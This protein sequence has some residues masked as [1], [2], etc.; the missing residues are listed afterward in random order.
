MG[1]AP[2]VADRLT[3]VRL[4]IVIAVVTIAPSAYAVRP[5]I[6]DDARVVGKH[7]AQLETWV[8]YE[9]TSLQHWIVPAI[10]P[11]APLEVT[12]GGVHGIV[13]EPNQRY[14]IAAP[15]LQAKLLLHEAKPNQLPGVALIAGTF[16]PFGFGGFESPPSGFI[17]TAVTQVIGDDA[18]L[19]H[20]NLGFAGAQVEERSSNTPLEREKHARYRFTWG[21]AT[22][23]RLYRAVN[24][25]A[26]VFSGDPYAEVAGGAVQGG[27]RFVL[28]NNVQLDSTAGSGVWGDQQM[29]G[30][31]S[32][33]LRVVSDRLW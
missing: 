9:K 19:F 17:Y 14:S 25:A 30:W 11:I 6:T 29:S 2:A 18:L 31:V 27:F 12:M 8:R 21:L 23:L 4:A 28:S 7:Q 10:G 20:G 32:T 26:E 16:L 1:T 22:Q 33:G 3:A 24:L 13:I 5:F 15:F